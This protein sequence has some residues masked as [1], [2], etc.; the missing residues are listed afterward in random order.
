VDQSSGSG[1]SP[2]ATSL[3][4]LHLVGLLV[5]VRR[6][7]VRA[8]GWRGPAVG[9]VLRLAV[10]GRRWLPALPGQHCVQTS[11]DAVRHARTGADQGAW[12]P[13]AINGDS[14]GE[15][16]RQ[17]GGNARAP[18]VR[19]GRHRSSRTS[20]RT[21]EATFRLGCPL[22]VRQSSRPH[23]A[24]LFSGGATPIRADP[25]HR[26]VTDEDQALWTMRRSTNTSNTSSSSRSRRTERCSRR[27]ASRACRPPS[28]LCGCSIPAR[29]RPCR[30]RS[31]R[32]LA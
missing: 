28:P 26:A 1:Q 2:F 32:R 10:V 23:T 16:G 30:A 7:G 19:L 5:S 25:R 14:S 24:V 9:T 12:M 31:F 13:T 11:I 27:P 20:C 17:S 3:L 6:G 18:L 22:T 8:G 4:S 29:H 15:R 21:A